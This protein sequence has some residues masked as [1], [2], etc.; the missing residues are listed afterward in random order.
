MSDNECAAPSERLVSK[1]ADR[2]GTTPDD[3]R[4]PL[5]EN[6]DLEALDS[7]FGERIDG[8]ARNVD[9]YLEFEYKQYRIHVES[10][11]EISIDELEAT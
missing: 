7:L 1:L 3:L 2:E 6:I 10:D 4:P 5:Y 11:G 8:T 9:G